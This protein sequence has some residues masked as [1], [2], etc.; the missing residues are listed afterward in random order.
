M[1]KEEYKEILEKEG[2]E[3]LLEIDDYDCKI[4]RVG[5]EYS[6]HLCGYVR[7]PEIHPFYNLEYYEID[8]DV[9]GGLTYSSE[10]KNGY[11][12][13]FDCAHYNDITPCYVGSFFTTHLFTDE[14]TYKDMDYVEKELIRLVRQIKALA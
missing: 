1:I 2:N 8:V 6:G 7:I 14:G 3:R 13:G 11:W 12:I 9:H 4:L 5:L 10:E